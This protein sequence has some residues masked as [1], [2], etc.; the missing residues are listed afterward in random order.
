MVRQLADAASQVQCAL[1]RLACLAAAV[2]VILAAVAA[3][4]SIPAH[5]GTRQPAAQVLQSVTT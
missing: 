1:G 3:M 4:A 2:L 5:A